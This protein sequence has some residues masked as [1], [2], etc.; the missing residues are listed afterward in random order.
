MADPALPSEVGAQSWL[1]HVLG[2]VGVPVPRA[3][4]GLSAK[5]TAPPV[6]VPGL[7]RLHVQGP[8]S[9]QEDVQVA[10]GSTGQSFSWNGLR[11]P[12]STPD[13]L[14]P[15]PRA[16]RPACSWAGDVE[17]SSKAVVPS[18]QHLGSRSYDL[19][20][21]PTAGISWNLC[22]TA[23]SMGDWPWHLP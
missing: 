20:R 19:H 4:S 3:L 6:P 11:V 23:F 21:A 14:H 16:H 1:G 15:N 8:G 7:S 2:L 9:G 12:V 22:L 17:H 13:L 10:E 18:G 5:L